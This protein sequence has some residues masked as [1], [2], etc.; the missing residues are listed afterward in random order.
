MFAVAVGVA[1]SPRDLARGLDAL[2]L[3]DRAHGA[4]GDVELVLVALVGLEK[5][6]GVLQGLGEPRE[7]GVGR[8]VVGECGR[9]WG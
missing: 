4:Q 7:R 8:E 9:V 6:D 1:H 2:D 5:L 3:A